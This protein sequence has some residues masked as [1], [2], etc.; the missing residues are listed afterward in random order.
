MSVTVVCECTN[1]FSLKDE[2]AGM[3]VKC[4]RCGRA[5]RAGS[6]DLT[7]ASEADP[8]FGRNVFLMR[9]QLRFNE[10]YEITDEQ[11]K[12]ILFVERPRHFL[13]RRVFCAPRAAAPRPAHPAFR[14]R[15]GNDQGE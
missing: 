10:R 11:G 1:T 14:R 7:P 13:R 4:P 15:Y 2:Y 5:V 12:G 8:I 9:Q 6:S 3:T